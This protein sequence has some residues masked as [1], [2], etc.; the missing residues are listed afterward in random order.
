MGS[1]EKQESDLYSFIREEEGKDRVVI[2]VRNPRQ[3]KRLSE[4]WGITV[5]DELLHSLRERFGE[6]NVKVVEKSIEK[7][8]KMNYT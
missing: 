5:S 1:F 7:Q 4:N 3:V 6:A 8:G 2:Y